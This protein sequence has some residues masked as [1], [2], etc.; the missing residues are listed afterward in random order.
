MT[1]PDQADLWLLKN[2]PKLADKTAEYLLNRKIRDTHCSGSQIFDETEFT[3][4]EEESQNHEAFFQFVENQHWLNAEVKIL[5][6]GIAQDQSLAKIGQCL[7]GISKQA[8]HKR[9][10]KHADVIQYLIKIWQGQD[11]NPPPQPGGSIPYFIDKNQ[12]LAFDFGGAV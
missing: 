5:V 3:V 8:V 2:D 7:G 4:Q 12:Q 11:N 10:H 6:L 9:L 1:T